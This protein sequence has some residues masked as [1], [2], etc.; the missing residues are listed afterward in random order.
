MSRTGRALQDA[1]RRKCYHPSAAFDAFPRSALDLGVPARF[2]EQVRRHGT[3]PAVESDSGR[4]TYSQLNGV[5]NDIAHALLEPTEGAAPLVAV[6]ADQGAMNVAALL[7]ILKAGA[8]FVPLDTHWPVARMRWVLDRSHIGV[9]LA[10]AS[11]APLAREITGANQRVLVLEGLV[12][13]SG[14]PDPR[15]SID[16][17]APAYVLYTSG[18]T[19]HPKGVRHSH[20]SLSHEVLRLTNALHVCADDRQSLL[21]ANSGGAISDAFTA[22]LNGAAVCPIDVL[23]SGIDGLVEW[24]TRERVTIW[25]STPSLFRAVWNEFP[26]TFLLRDLRIVFLCGEPVTASDLDAYRTYAGRDS[27]F[28]NCLGSTE[29]ATVT[30]QLIDRDAAVEPGPVPIG[31][32][33]ED[34]DVELVDE[35]GDIVTGAASGE[36]V[37]RS[38]YLADGYVD[39]PRLTEQLFREDSDDVACRRYFSGDTATRLN[40]GTLIYQGRKATRANVSGRT[41]ELAE[42]EMALQATHGIREAIADV[43]VDERGTSRLVAYVVADAEPAPTIDSVRLL[44]EARLPAFMIPSSLVFVEG[45]PLTGSGKADRRVL[46]ERLRARPVVATTAAPSSPLEVAVA[47][48]FAEMLHVQEVEAQDSF[49]E[50]GGKSLATL[51]VLSR[52]KSSYGADHRPASVLR[53]ADGRGYRARRRTRTRRASRSGDA[54]R[55]ARRD[56]SVGQRR[57]EPVGNARDMGLVEERRVIAL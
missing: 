21:R 12:T 5:A 27:L 2:E 17:D 6:L 33:V 34:M 38:R 16:A 49:F 48:I 41:F 24:V 45:I 1:L 4:L 30:L 29:C 36:I 25:R 11:R 43:V 13:A 7:G 32:A 28:V 22:L 56:R 39:E 8:A 14:R 31:Y 23:E 35:S 51:R 42:V 50:L 15:V 47:R 54:R 3:R 40:D 26:S 46:A 19:G 10:S 52:I 18:S 20:R 53:A 57:A 37:V 44:L 9:V 55:L